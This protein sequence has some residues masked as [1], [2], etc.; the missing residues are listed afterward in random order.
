MTSTKVERRS[1]WQL[2]SLMAIFAVMTLLMVSHQF[3]QASDD[4][5]SEFKGV[6]ESKPSTGRIGTWTISGKDFEVDSRN[7]VYFHSARGVGYRF[8]NE[9]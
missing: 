7:P 4:H 6:V 3:V 8:V 9:G 5:G 2:L 1:S